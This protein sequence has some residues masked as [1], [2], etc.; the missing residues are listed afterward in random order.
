MTY[1]ASEKE[2]GCVF[3]RYF[4]SEPGEDRKN[5]I[6][7]RDGLGFVM[8]NKYPYNS[9]HLL[10]IPNRHV[11][12]L[13]ELTDDELLAL[14]KLLTRSLQVLEKIYTPDGFN[15]GMNLGK[16]AGAGIEDHLHYHIVPRWNGDTNFISILADIRVVPQHLETTYDQLK[17]GFNT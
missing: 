2:E 13:T 14:Q 9:A 3:C 1:I 12:R 10:I 5:L 8:M 16:P 11:A 6:L 4:E 17:K 15:I 7:L